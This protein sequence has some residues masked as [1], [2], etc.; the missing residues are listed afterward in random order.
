[1]AKRAQKIS[2][3]GKPWAVYAR[4]SKANDGAL[5]KVEHQIKLCTDYAEQRGLTVH[6]IYQEDTLSAWKRNVRRPQWDAMMEAAKQ[7]EIAGVLVWKIDRFTRRPKDM[8]TLIELAAD[9]GLRIE[10]PQA[11]QID[12]T[13]NMGIQQARWM[14]MQAASESGNT[15]ERVKNTLHRKMREGKP[16]GS[17]RA[18]GFE[19]GGEVQ[20]PA[21]VAIV[22]EMAQR[23]LA[24]EPLQ[25]LAADLNSREVT[26][27]RDKQWTGANLARLLGLARYGGLVESNG[28]IVGTMPGDPVLD[29]DTYDE[30]QALLASRRRGARP[31]GR[32]PLTGVL[33]CSTC[34]RTMNGATRHVALADGSRPR[35]YRCMIQRG[36]C[37]RVV[38][39]QPVEDLVGEHMVGL[40]S[41]PENAAKVQAEDAHLNAARAT[42]FAAQEAIQRRRDSLEV[43]WNAFEVSEEA[44][45]KSRA[46]LNA[47]LLK[48]SAELTELSPA[49]TM[50]TYNAAGD[51]SEMTDDEKRLVIREYR[52]RIAILPKQPG[53]RRFD[54][55]RVT[56]PS[57]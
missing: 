27:S 3:E 55:D 42:A 47:R 8:E 30:V 14:A 4:L 24:G 12:L 43:K 20:R 40:L 51:W 38:L 32:F 11:G 22:R 7:G 19:I 50:S 31:S 56:F 48:V 46:D 33:T 35:E 5:E 16:M 21:E 44:Y 13:T 29:R 15:S 49:G 28:E 52:V 1:M 6:H 2:T 10:G 9:H 25:A 39:A 41:E 45:E 34:Q 57:V 37:G 54:P 26:T 36:G 53:T 17:G 23:M 18:F